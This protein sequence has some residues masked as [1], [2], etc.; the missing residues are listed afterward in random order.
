MRQTSSVKSSFSS[1]LGGGDVFTDVGHF[2][3]QMIHGRQWQIPSF[4]RPANNSTIC[5]F[6][7][8]SSQQYALLWKWR[9]NE[10]HASVATILLT[11]EVSILYTLTP[12]KD[13]A[14]FA[15][16]R[17]KLLSEGKFVYV[18]T[19]LMLYHRS[20]SFIGFRLIYLFNNSRSVCGIM[21]SSCLCVCLTEKCAIIRQTFVWNQCRGP[22]TTDSLILAKKKKKLNSVALVRKRTI[23][24]ERPPL[25]AK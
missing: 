21:A 19:T 10:F 18:I 1:N 12:R 25:S 3:S 7:I 23:P 15:M 17:L 8:I 20:P 14:D 6:F 22:I 24:T 9:H 11:S 5:V 2:V 16:F 4:A 13:S